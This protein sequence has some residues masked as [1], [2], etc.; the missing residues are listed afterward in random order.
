MTTY[1][2]PQRKSTV[3][4]IDR[5]S[6]KLGGAKGSLEENI[7]KFSEK[8]GLK[9][10]G[11][12]AVRKQ[13]RHGLPVTYRQGKQIIKRHPDGKEEVLAEIAPVKFSVPAGVRI[14]GSS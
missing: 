7:V 11:K 8:G 14:I 10:I 2:Y 13:K 1:S 4:R 9:K 6:A 12:A 3:K 5:H